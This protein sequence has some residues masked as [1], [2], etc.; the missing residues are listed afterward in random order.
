[1]AHISFAFGPLAVILL[2]ALPVLGRGLGLGT[3]VH[4]LP[5]QCVTSVCMVPAEVYLP[6]AQTSLAEIAT[7]PPRLAGRP[8]LGLGTTVQAVPS[9][10]RIIVEVGPGGVA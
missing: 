6:T 2:R 3:T 9:Q 10:C 7:T 1:M 4:W 8:G 5:S